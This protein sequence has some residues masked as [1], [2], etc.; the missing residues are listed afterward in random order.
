MTS[1]ELAKL[2]VKIVGALAT[3]C[4][5]TKARANTKTAVPRTG[6]LIDTAGMK[7]RVGNSEVYS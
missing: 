4:G 2:F 5:V 7:Y 1:T 6:V 3:S